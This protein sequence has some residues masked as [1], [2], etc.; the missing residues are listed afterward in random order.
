[1]RA[2][3]PPGYLASPPENWKAPL[4]KSIVGSIV[5]NPASVPNV[6]P[7]LPRTL[8][9]SQLATP[10]RYYTPHH[11]T[12]PNPT[13]KLAQDDMPCRVVWPPTHDLLPCRGCPR[14]PRDSFSAKLSTRALCLNVAVRSCNYCPCPESKDR[15]AA[16]IQDMCINWGGSDQDHIAQD[17]SEK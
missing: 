1:M 6:T 10:P 14:P 13:G 16:T 4:P 5:S 8:Y 11:P 9:A 7:I 3:H 12:S 15:H 2:P 17:T